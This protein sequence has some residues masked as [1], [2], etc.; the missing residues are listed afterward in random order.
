MLWLSVT[1]EPAQ[2]KTLP[3]RQGGRGRDPAR[4]QRAAGRG[5]FRA[6]PAELPRIRDITAHILRCQQCE[7]QNFD[8]TAF[9]I[10]FNIVLPSQNINSSPSIIISQNHPRFARYPF[11]ESRFPMS[12]FCLCC[13]HIGAAGEDK[14]PDCGAPLVPDR[15]DEAKTPNAWEPRS[16]F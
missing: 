12:P 1:F 10:F 11:N 16:R 15:A 4:G 9:N 13:G 2:S 3:R 6:L 7:N 5:C 14:C 8:K